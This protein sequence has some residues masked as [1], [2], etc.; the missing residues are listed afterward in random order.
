MTDEA[1]IISQ[2]ATLMKPE[3]DNSRL[4]LL[5]KR[6]EFQIY[7]TP[8]RDEKVDDLYIGG[9]VKFANDE[10][11]SRAKT[12]RETL[13][14][15]ASSMN[16][17]SNE[18]PGMY[19]HIS[20]TLSSDLKKIIAD[21]LARSCIDDKMKNAIPALIDQVHSDALKQQQVELEIFSSAPAPIGQGAT[22]INVHGNMFGVIQTGAQSSANVSQNISTEEAS[23]FRSVLEQLRKELQKQN[24]AEDVEPAL[25]LIDKADEELAKP[26]P[27]IKK[28]APYLTG[29]S[30]VVGTLKNGPG[31]YHAL[32]LIAAA[33]GIPLP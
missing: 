6:D 32:K 18:L 31:A 16:L 2:V 25:L 1:K 27:A 21:E 19:E 3:L 30:A 9:L 15:V 5:R 17:S 20:K 13:C 23:E 8:G 26:E 28:V 24:E 4:R 33:H 10:Q 11:Y 29:I 12:A 14:R 22:N 7:M